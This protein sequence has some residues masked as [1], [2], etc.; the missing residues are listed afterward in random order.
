LKQKG[1]CGLCP[2]PQK[3]GRPFEPMR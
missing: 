2:H 3:A 1:F